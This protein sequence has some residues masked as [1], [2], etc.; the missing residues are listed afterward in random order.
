[1]KKGWKE[2]FYKYSINQLLGVVEWFALLIALGVFVFC[3]SVH[4]SNWMLKEE[5]NKNKLYHVK[6]KKNKKKQVFFDVA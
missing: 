2:M 5:V 4:L 6:H 3:I 1:M